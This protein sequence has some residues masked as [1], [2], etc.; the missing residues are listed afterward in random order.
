M[1]RRRLQGWLRSIKVELSLVI[2]VI[3]AYALHLGYDIICIH[4][5]SMIELSILL[6]IQ[7]RYP[8][9]FIVC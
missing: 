4:L 2:G 5:P 1:L 7:Y 3:I 6:Q 8:I 9:D